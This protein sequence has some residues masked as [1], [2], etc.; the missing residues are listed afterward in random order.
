MINNRQLNVLRAIV[1]ITTVQRGPRT[2]EVKN[3]IE[4]PSDIY[5]TR[6]L[7]ALAHR[8]LIDCRVDTVHGDGW[9]AT[10]L[11]VQEAKR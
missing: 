6:T 1:E 3:R 2:G 5:D 10:A 9:A 4:R 8:N 7:R 11:G